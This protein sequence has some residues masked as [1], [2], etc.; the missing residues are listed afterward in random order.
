MQR[1]Y[2][3]QVRVCV[4]VYYRVNSAVFFRTNK[5]LYYTTRTQWTCL[6]EAVWNSLDSICDVSKAFQLMVPSK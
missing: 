2:L 5:P 3:R 1:G 6:F 4:V